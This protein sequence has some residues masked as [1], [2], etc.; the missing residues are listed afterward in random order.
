MAQKRVQRQIA[1]FERK[2]AVDAERARIARDLHDDLGSSLT[3]VALLSELVNTNIATR[4]DRASKHASEIFTTAQEMTRS[5]DEIVW[6]VDPTHDTIERFSIFL[7]TFMQNYARVAGLHA[8]FDFPESLPARP[9][10]ANARHHLYL[11]IKE[12]LHNVVKHAE[13]TEVHVALKVEPKWLTLIISD[14]GKGFDP[15][16]QVFAPGADGLR[17]LQSRL[18]QVGGTCTR[19]SAPGKGTLVQ[20]RVPLE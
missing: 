4:P 18:Q 12:V 11:A 14:N 7:G 15:A 6:A 5:L 9:L 2:Q 3:Q 16:K 1:A 19:E 13:A 8:R 20:M 17:N 10:P